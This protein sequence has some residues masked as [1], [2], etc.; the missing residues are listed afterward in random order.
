ME[1]DLQVRIVGSLVHVFTG[2]MPMQHLKH[3]LDMNLAKDM[4]S[5]Q[6]EANGR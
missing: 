6:A 4:R 3:C 5:E 1:R 2:V